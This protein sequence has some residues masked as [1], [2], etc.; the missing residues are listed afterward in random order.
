VIKET[1]VEILPFFTSS[2]LLNI[3]NQA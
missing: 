3:V 2:Q 1:S